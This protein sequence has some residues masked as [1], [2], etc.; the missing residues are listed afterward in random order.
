MK[1]GFNMILSAF[2]KRCNFRVIVAAAVL[3]FGIPHLTAAHENAKNQADVI[4]VGGGLSGL[5]AA[6]TLV[7]AGHSVI[8]LEARDRVGGRTWTKQGEKGVW[9][10]MG[11][12]WIGPGQTH[13]LALAKTLGL[14][15]F[16]SFDTGNGI[17]F[18]KGTK[19]SYS[20]KNEV[21]PFPA[22]DVNAYHE[23]MAKID[24]LAKTVPVDAPWK[25]PHAEELDGQT[26]A[27][28]MDSSVP[29]ERARFLLRVFML[30]YFASEPK[31]VSFLHFLFYVN[32]G[33]G[34]HNLH[35][36]GIAQRIVGGTQ[37]LSDKMAQQLGGRVVLNTPVREIDQ[38]SG[39]VMIKTDHGNFSGKYVIVAMTPALSGRIIYQPVLPA[40]RDQ[41]TQRAP[42][43]SSIK[44]HAVYPEAFWRKKGLSGQV[45]S[46][47]D[48]ISL[49]VDNS[50][51]E[52]K[53]GIL[54]GFIEADEA[55][56]WS[57]RSEA[58]K[59]KA[60]IAA[61]VKYFGPEAASPTAFYQVDW[62]AQPW[63]RGCFSG[64]MP[65]GT[66][67]GFPDVLR[68]PVGRIHWAGTETATQWY[69]Y[70]DGAIAS[71]E[72][73]GNEVSQLLK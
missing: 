4:V 26:V 34:L 73:A 41:F 24:E 36:A 61:F 51:P 52:G 46:G 71:G 22:E 33:G 31:D 15:I 48:P 59:K 38:T 39:G 47:E 1:K 30:G 68:K 42:M 56:K 21:F 6:R 27:S 17:L 50:P 16:P 32:A 11:G 40:D 25:A 69:A 18:Y 20:L 72:R 37:Q 62:A 13:V 49:V 70:M 14:T 55:R 54:A 57:N 29:N 45:I 23:A 63:S 60:T 3:C 12:Q 64:V 19:G 7:A 5:S 66:W 43:G 8:V 28:W 9:I 53:P 2:I 67:T 35:T 58:D 65:A 44:L 10:D